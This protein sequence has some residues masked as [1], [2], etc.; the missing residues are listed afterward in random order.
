MAQ[1]TGTVENFNTNYDKYSISVNGTWYSTKLEWAKVKPVAGDEVTFDDAGGKYTKNLKIVTHGSGA[2]ATPT[3]G[4]SGAGLK[5]APVYQPKTFPLDA[6]HPDRC[7]VRQNALR[8]AA[9][10]MAAMISP[11]T[12]WQPDVLAS[13]TISLAEAFEYYTSGQDIA[14]LAET[15]GAD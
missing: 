9:V 6:L 4:V 5:P 15:M 10:L 2:T 8:H 11:D 1:V 14:D 7:I 12:D 13:Q 3:S